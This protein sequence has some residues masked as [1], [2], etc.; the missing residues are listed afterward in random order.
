[1]DQQ[2]LGDNLAA[3]FAAAM[4]DAY[5]SYRQAHPEAFGAPGEWGPDVK[6]IELHAQYEPTGRGTIA[7]EVVSRRPL[8]SHLE[9]FTLFSHAQ[10]VSLRRRKANPKR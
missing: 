8:G 10:D 3:A 5:R 7:V 9:A 2:R 6:R 4:R 1:M